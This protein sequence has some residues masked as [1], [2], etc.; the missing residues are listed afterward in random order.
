MK[1]A[2]YKKSLIRATV[3][4]FILFIFKIYLTLIGIG[5]AFGGEEMKDL[6]SP[7]VLLRILS[8]GYWLVEGIQKVCLSCSKMN[9]WIF[10]LELAT[11]I[12]VPWVI[13]FLLFQ[14]AERVRL[15]R[16]G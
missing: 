2:K 11:D 16:L 14:F 4:L 8:P 1:I 10:G 3:G 13:M 5:Q 15:R 7:E 9:E 12:I 6:R